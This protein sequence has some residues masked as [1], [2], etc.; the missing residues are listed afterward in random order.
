LVIVIAND[1]F[2]P[3]EMPVFS[4]CESPILCIECYFG[5]SFGIGTMRPYPISDRRMHLVDVER[6]W[7]AI[8]QQAKE[9][10]CFQ[11]S[12][13]CLAA[14]K[15]SIIDLIGSSTGLLIVLAL[16]G[17]GSRPIP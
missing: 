15:S 11:Y 14:A 5:C 4:D 1:W 13:D 16:A 6:A 3:D 8:I 10:F 17:Q 7:R 2:K 12:F 9:R